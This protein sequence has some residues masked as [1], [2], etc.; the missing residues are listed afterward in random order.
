[1]DV[2]GCISINIFL[3]SPQK[4]AGILN[5]TA[6][7]IYRL[8]QRRRVVAVCDTQVGQVG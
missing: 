6:Y 7:Q 4:S 1:M 5:D 3:C 8:A 2:C